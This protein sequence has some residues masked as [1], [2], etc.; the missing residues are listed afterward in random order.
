MEQNIQTD[1]ATVV[2]FAVFYV[3]LFYCVNFYIPYYPLK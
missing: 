1:G 3:N 2:N